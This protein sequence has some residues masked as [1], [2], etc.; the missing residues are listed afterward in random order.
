MEHDKND[1][2]S[3]HQKDDEWETPVS[4]ALKNAR[5]IDESGEE[6]SLSVAQDAFRYI[7]RLGISTNEIFPGM[8][9]SMMHRYFG[10]DERFAGLRDDP[11]KLADKAIEIAEGWKRQIA[12]QKMQWFDFGRLQ[13][14]NYRA[15]SKITGSR[16]YSIIIQ[17]SDP[18]I[19]ERS[20]LEIES[21]YNPY[22][23][24]RQKIEVLLNAKVT[25]FGNDEVFLDFRALQD[26]LDLNSIA[27]VRAF[28]DI[29]NQRDAV[30]GL[31]LMFKQAEIK[32]QTNLEELQSLRT[33]LEEAQAFSL[34][35]YEDQLAGLQREVN[36][37]WQDNLDRL[38]D[39]GPLENKR[40][41]VY[42]K[43]RHPFETLAKRYRENLGGVPNWKV[44]CKRH[45]FGNV[46]ACVKETE[47][48]KEY[49]I[50]LGKDETNHVFA[51]TFFSKIG[52]KWIDEE[53][54]YVKATDTKLTAYDLFQVYDKVSA[55]FDLKKRARG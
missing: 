47:P 21:V 4:E 44:M 34:A 16:G 14:A 7:R 26:D 2:A 43:G 17:S 54:K 45:E 13:S 36:Q 9:R 50:A 23:R 11:L 29:S 20:L 24:N 33:D 52:K 30:D 42:F 37:D 25:V 51:F 19:G 22:W 15:K 10:S 3:N 39:E 38:A 48:D 1:K 32:E 5:Y 35:A 40:F 18:N 27:P 12:A 46:Y 55:K 49:L 31:A 28:P 53:K 6:T 41:T 8:N